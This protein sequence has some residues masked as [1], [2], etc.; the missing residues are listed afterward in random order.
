MTRLWCGSVTK[1]EG[2]RSPK[3]ITFIRAKFSRNRDKLGPEKY[4]ALRA[5]PKRVTEFLK[6]INRLEH[7]LK[8]RLMKYLGDQ[9]WIK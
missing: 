4:S 2:L 6:A 7:S 8:V 5:S 9:K 3:A 1:Y